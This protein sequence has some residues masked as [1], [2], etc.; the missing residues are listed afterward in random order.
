MGER[1][2]QKKIYLCNR[3]RCAVCHSECS[4][5]TDAR[6]ALNP[7]APFIKHSVTGDYAQEG[8]LDGLRP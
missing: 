1:K 4:G 7:N 5:T 6:F 8:S 3:K 2:T